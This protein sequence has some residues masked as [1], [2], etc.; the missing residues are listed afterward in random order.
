M[1]EF[2]VINKYTGELGILSRHSWCVIVEQRDI[3]RIFP[4]TKQSLADKTSPL[5]TWVTIG[6]L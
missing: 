1:G 2:V 4:Y 6:K 5:Y 3:Y